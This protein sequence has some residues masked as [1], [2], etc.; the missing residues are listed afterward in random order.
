MKLKIEIKNRWTD[1]VLF[2]YEKEN[3][4]VKETLIKAV[5]Q[6]FVEEKCEHLP[7]VDTGIGYMHCQACNEGF[8]YSEWEQMQSGSKVAESVPVPDFEFTEWVGNNACL[9][10]GSWYLN[11]DYKEVTTPYT[12]AELFSG[13][14]QEFLNQQKGDI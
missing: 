1:S 5:K 11:E 2:E 9:Y 14:Y 7:I 3:N 10:K 6:E 8:T 4:T 12:T 13:P